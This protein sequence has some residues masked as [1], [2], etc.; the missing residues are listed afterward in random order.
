MAVDQLKNIPSITFLAKTGIHQPLKHYSA[1]ELNRTIAA[2]NARLAVLNAVW[3]V[4][5]SGETPNLDQA[6]ALYER[7]ALLIMHNHDYTFAVKQAQRL[8][9]LPPTKEAA[10]ANRAKELIELDLETALAYATRDRLHELIE[11]VQGEL[12]NLQFNKMR[13]RL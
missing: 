4:H 8:G 2:K 12:L 3:E 9:D 1:N 13:P 5:L 11:D 6:K 7:D 10:F